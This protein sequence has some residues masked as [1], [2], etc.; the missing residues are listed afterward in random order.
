MSRVGSEAKDGS[1]RHILVP[2][3]DFYMTLR[4]VGIMRSA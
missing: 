3:R 2:V 4:R 1:D